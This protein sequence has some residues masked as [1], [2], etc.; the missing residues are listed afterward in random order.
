M[1]SILTSISGH[2]K[3]VL[4]LAW[5]LLQKTGHPYVILLVALILLVTIVYVI[6]KKY[7]YRFDSMKDVFMYFLNNQYRIMSD[8]Q[9]I[10]YRTVIEYGGSFVSFGI[11][12]TQ[13]LN[14]K[15]ERK[16]YRIKNVITNESFIKC[17][18]VERKFTY[19]KFKMMYH[20]ILTG[21]WAAHDDTSTQSA[22]TDPV[23]FTLKNY[24]RLPEKLK[25]P[26]AIY[27]LCKFVDAGWLNDDIEV[28]VEQKEGFPNK[29]TAGF[30]AYEVC[31]AINETKYESIF[32]QLGSNWDR[33]A[34]A[35]ESAHR[36]KKDQD[37]NIKRRIREILN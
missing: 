15:S 23:A 13:F 36:H 10:Y 5:T 6:I 4:E 8:L 34:S 9:H 12:A 2:V 33:I 18:F 32:S 19:K 30:I 20:N 35:K 26:K 27:T 31:N 25:N 37:E 7:R 28:T 1:E 16:I 24:N 14:T 17:Y 3:H 21:Q 29:M 11:E 22:K